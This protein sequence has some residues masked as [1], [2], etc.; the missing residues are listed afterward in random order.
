MKD[1]QKGKILN[2]QAAAVQVCNYIPAKLLR[3]DTRFMFA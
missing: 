2:L 1:L 3:V